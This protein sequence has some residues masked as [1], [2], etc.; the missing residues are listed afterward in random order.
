MDYDEYTLKKLTTL[1]KAYAIAIAQG[2]PYE[3]IRDS[4]IALLPHVPPHLQYYS[5]RIVGIVRH[6]GI[7]HHTKVH[8]QH[9]TCAEA[10]AEL[11]AS[12]DNK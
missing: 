2:K 4:I 5:K 12:L 6:N 3:H 11:E 1:R 9:K 10:M 8:V 7:L